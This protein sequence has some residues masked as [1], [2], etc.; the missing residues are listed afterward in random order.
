M[1]H[2]LLT[3]DEVKDK[4]SQGKK[5]LLA[6]EEE[7]LKQLP[8]GKWI[9]GTIPYFMAEEG[10]LETREKVFVTEL[11]DF[12]EDISIKVYNEDTISDVLAVRETM[13]YRSMFRC[14]R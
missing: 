9:G 6:G 13:Y 4:V 3:I 5:L 10:G 12:I 11:P 7:I 2:I 1:T 14:Y 8:K